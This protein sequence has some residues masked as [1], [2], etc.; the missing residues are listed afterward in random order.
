MWIFNTDANKWQIHSDTLSKY[1]YDNLKEDLESVRL[2]SRCLSGALYLPINDL[3]NI[4]NSYDKEKIGYYINDGVYSSVNYPYSGSNYVLNSTN[5]N[6]FY[7]KYLRE[8]AFTIKSLFTPTRLINSELNNYYY[9]DVASTTMSYNF[10][11]SN[12][13]LIIDDIVLKEG[14]RVLIKD[15]ITII[16]LPISIDPEEYFTNI[17]LVS[18]YY[19]SESFVSDVTY[20]YYNKDNGI[21][22]YTDNSLIK[23][24]EIN[25]YD[26]AYNYKVSVK[27]GTVNAGKQF[28]LNRLRNGYFP[29]STETQNIE[30]SLKHTWLLRNRIDYHNIFDINYYDIIQHSTQSYY[31]P[32]DAFTYTIPSRVI[33]VGDFGVIINNQDKLSSAAT[34]SISH[35]IDNKYKDN[36]NSI[37]E[38]NGFYWACGNNATLI[39]I[40]KIDFNI[41]AYPI[42]EL[43]DLKSISFC[44]DINGVVVGKYNIIYYTRNGGNDWIKLLYDEY[45]SYSYNKVLHVEAN[46]IF[47]SGDTGVFIELYYNNGSWVAYKR[48]ISKQ[49]TSDD[50]YILVEDINDMYYHSGVII[51]QKTYTE[52]ATSNDFAQ[53]LKYLNDNNTNYPYLKIS[54]NSSYFNDLT[55]NGSE[56]YIAFNIKNQHGD[57]YLSDNFNYDI[58]DALPYASSFDIWND[59]LG[60]SNYIFSKI[61]PT[62]SNN[63]LLIGTYSVYINIVYNYD[64]VNKTQYSGYLQ[65]FQE[66]TLSV[67]SGNM[68]L[69]CANN[70]IMINYDINNLITSNT[71]NFIYSNFTH[72]FSDI[73]SLAMNNNDVYFNGSSINKLKLYD[74]YIPD[75]SGTINSITVS[76]VTISQQYVN[77]IFINNYGYVYVAG[78]HSLLKMCDLITYTFND[79]DPTFNNTLTSKLLFLDYD[80]ASKLNFFTSDGIYN[81]PVSVTFSAALLTNSATSSIIITNKSNEYNWFN[82]YAD[83]EKTFK[84][85]TQISDDNS[86]EFLNTFKYTTYSTAFTFSNVQL[87][88]N[89]YEIIELAPNINISTASRYIQETTD[90]NTGYTS[91]FGVLLY[92]YLIIFNIPDNN[93]SIGDIIYFNTDII[94]CNLLVNRIVNNFVYCYSNFNQNIINCLLNTTTNIFIKNLNRYESVNDFIQYYTYHPLSHGYAFDLNDGII[95]LSGLFNN[96]TAYYNLQADL[97]INEMDTY[98]VKYVDAFL[99]FGYSPIYNILDYLSNIDNTIF[100]PDKKLVILPEYLNMP[101][102]GGNSLTDNIIY[103]DSGSNTNKI[104]FGKNFKFNWESLLLNTFIDMNVITT[105]T[106]YNLKKLLITNKYYDTT[107]DAYVMEFHKKIDIPFN[108]QC[109]GFD[110]LSRNTL[111]DISSDLQ[112]I[113]N[114]QRT[115]TIKSGSGV[116]SFFNMENELN[117]KINTDSYLKAFISDYDIRNKVTGIIYSDKDNQ[118]AV[119]I[120]NISKTIN[121]DIINTFNYVVGSDVNLGLYTRNSHQLKI[122][123]MIYVSFNGGAGSSQELNPQYYGLQTVIA[124]IDANRLITSKKYNNT[125]LVQDF[126]SIIFIKKDPFF[127]YQPVD[128]FDVGIDKEVTRSVEITPHNIIIANNIH[129]LNNINL[130]KYKIQLVDGL[131]LAEI[132]KNYSW[133][134]EAEVSDAVIGR[135]SNGIIWYSGVWKFGRWFGGTWISGTWI[136]GDWYGGTWKAF[137]IINNIISVKINTTYI[138]NNAS[139]W[140]GG[141]WFDGIWE[142]GTWYNGRWYGGTWNTGI[143]YNGIWNDG[144]W[145]SGYFKGG[146]WVRGAWIQGYFNSDVK[147]SYWLS[148]EFKSGDFENGIWYNGN[149]G[150]VNNTL[151][152]FGTKSTNT[153]TSIWHSG[154]WI[155]GD[156]H[157]FLNTDLLG[158]PIKSVVHK[159]S[160]WKTGY[161]YSGNFYGGVVYNINFKSSKWYGGIL[162]DIQI[163]GVNAILPANTSSNSIVLNGIFKFNIGDDITIIDNNNNT[164]LSPIGNN[165][166]PMKYRINN[167]SE[168]DYLKQTTLYLNY[169]LSSLGIDS[170]ISSTTHSN[171]ETGLRIV[172]VFKDSTWETGVWKNGIF[173]KGYFKSG[174]WY[175]GLF[176]GIWGI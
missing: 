56:I 26:D 106:T 123:D 90:I 111:N 85:Y 9:V 74:M 149:F 169:D 105:A 80:I 41:I 12:N 65:S 14:H 54:I 76:T 1:N 127:N 24:N 16:T 147:P 21:Y 67:D 94:D 43:T 39:K 145:I 79:I 62:D 44:D 122:G 29:I 167:I 84:Y 150:N 48:K 82:Y 81:L 5:S 113:N 155:S 42:N 115:K 45:K 61:L 160:V 83:A 4:Y 55:F 10:T 37:V 88:N 91:S 69:M 107:L 133:L 99:N 25:N 165:T 103:I 173:I 97:I 64:T 72:S 77:K 100:T 101:G 49:L 134:L 151:V 164:F 128:I 63:N 176:D 17:E 158:N 119:N 19:I 68:L 157:S 8:N 36:I 53:S 161:W 144:T 87:T 162:E 166:T 32:I 93:F 92:D 57:V 175:N 23:Q 138:D 118:L 6:E 96:K 28:H 15:Q 102:N 71:N 108:T 22:L 60:D 154:I 132:N 172:S 131:S 35:I 104:I 59:G 170:T 126:G 66:Y 50:E 135:D 7:N 52:D 153:R 124:V 18:N 98:D 140:F 159:Y 125:S 148:G 110:L 78:N 171:C 95:T 46:K 174:M 120:L 34:Y 75:N 51:K 89:L 136:S 112:I 30:F 137:N 168:D 47:I 58:N 20:Y 73:K 11:Q 116:N 109:I 156:F 38:I 114:I 143:W 117:Y 163:C 86:V 129:S 3:S 27:S 33:S 139:K 13:N 130:Q 121:Y 142:G 146:I 40:S 152:R 141:R 31:N 70:N 2:Y